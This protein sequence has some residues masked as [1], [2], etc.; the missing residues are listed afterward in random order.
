MSEDLLRYDRFVERALRLVVRE[1]LQ[2]VARHGLP[3][4]H[5]LYIT[6]KTTFPGVDMPE[7][8]RTSYPEEMTIVLQY[9]FWDLL[10]EEEIFSVTLSFNDRR[11]RITVPFAAIS[12]FADPSVNFALQFQVGAEENG[13]AESPGPPE[14]GDAE[15]KSDDNVVTLDQFRKK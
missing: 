11:E 1:T 9:Q 3:G 4:A 13:A 15:A 12:A 10:V 8:L 2:Q 7:S 6:F 14:S 5:H